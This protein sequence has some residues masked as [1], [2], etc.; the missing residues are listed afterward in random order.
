MWEAFIKEAGSRKLKTLSR[1]SVGIIS[2][3]DRA[4]DVAKKVR[5]EN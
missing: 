2:S 1:S 3:L 4:R 5:L